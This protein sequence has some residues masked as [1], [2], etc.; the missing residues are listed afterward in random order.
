MCAQKIGRLDAAI[1]IRE[2]TVAG[3]LP[4]EW[5][6]SHTGG[7]H[8]P[9]SHF[10]GDGGISVLDAAAG[11]ATELDPLTNEPGSI[12]GLGPAPSAIAVGLGSAWV[13]DGED[14]TCIA[15]T[16]NLLKPRR[17]R[18]VRL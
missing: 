11:T 16:P 4:G 13:S 1:A 2:S 3:T 6:L 9:A 18:L 8:A 12:I 14:G 7:R 15:S 5:T 17:S 10:A